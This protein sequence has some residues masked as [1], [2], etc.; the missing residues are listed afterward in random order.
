MAD[1]K[2][3]SELRDKAISLGLC[4][5]WQELWSKDWDDMK[6]IERY[7]EGID[8]CLAN[9][10]PSVEYIKSHFSKEDLRKGGLFMDDK[11][12][13]LNEK[14]IVV[15]GSSDITAR[16][17]GDTVAEVYITDSATLKVYAKNHCH[18]ILHIIGNAQVDIQQ[19]DDATVLAIRHSKTCEI[20]VTK[21]SVTEREEYTYLKDI[22]D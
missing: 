1:S 2:K 7:K 19:E 21:G 18:V 3:N 9:D 11:R 8:F 12:S 15:R 6:M 22:L 16:Y 14:M 4:D 5:L 13:V 10:F 20:H 17:N